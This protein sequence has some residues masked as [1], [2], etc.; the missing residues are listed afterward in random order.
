M[1][2]TAI[3]IV[4]GFDRRGKWGKF[5]TD[6]ARSFPWIDICLRQIERHSKLSNYEIYVYDNT[7]L[8]EHRQ[9][10]HKYP[11]VRVFPSELLVQLSRPLEQQ[12]P[13]HVTN[14]F[15][16]RRIEM[17]HQDALDFLVSRLGN[18][19]EYIIT[20][21]TDAFPIQDGWIETL[22]GYL[23]DGSRLAGIY[24]DET[25][26][27]IQPFIHVSCL[28]IRKQDFFN[29]GL[30]FK[31]GKAQDVSQNITLE[32]LKRQAKITGLRRSNAN[33]VHFLLGGVYGNLVYHHGAG[34]RKARFHTSTDTTEDERIRVKLRNAVFQNLDAVVEELTACKY[35]TLKG[36]T[37]K[38][39]VIL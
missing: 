13:H 9:I 5:N 24:L 33:N 34:S 14:F 4:N 37:E 29:L 28:C 22:V 16:Q 2:K 1:E 6:E 20:L 36:K 15:M 18:E 11:K 32:L 26:P 35:E 17:W 23:K 3:L 7:R 27:K 8:K 25:A 19:I 10:M 12:F 21:D 31:M 30:S 39:L 38:Y